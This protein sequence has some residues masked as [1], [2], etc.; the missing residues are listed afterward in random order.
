[1]LAEFLKDCPGAFNETE[2]S[3]AENLEDYLVPEDSDQDVDWK[4]IETVIKKPVFG[5]LNNELV[6][7]LRLK[8]KKAID[9]SEKAAA[10]KDI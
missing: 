5:F 1:M 4:A 8:V 2:Y 10:S 3:L 6:K 7:K 9:D